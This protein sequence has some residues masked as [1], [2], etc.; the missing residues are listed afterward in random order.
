[1]EKILSQTEEGKKRKDRHEEKTNE[2]IAK[3]IAQ[4]NSEEMVKQPCGSGDRRQKRARD[5]EDEGEDEGRA[6]GFQHDGK[7]TKR[8]REEG[9]QG[10]EERGSARIAVDSQPSNVMGELAAL[11]D[12]CEPIGPS[13]LK[14]YN[15]HRFYD[16][17]TGEEL[18]PVLVAKACEGELQRFEKMQVYR[19]V[20]KTEAKQGKI[21]KVEWVW[22][23]KGMKTAPEVR[24]RLV[25]M[26]FGFNEPRE[27]LFT[28][29]PPLFAM[30]RLLS[31]IASQEKPR[32]KIIMLLDVKCAFLHG[33]TKRT[34]RIELLP[35]D[36]NYRCGKY[37]GLLEKAMYGTRDA[38]QI[39][40]EVVAE[41]M[42]R[43]GFK[44]SLRIHQS[45]SILSERFE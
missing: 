7:G 31:L 36:P 9:D 21:A 19:L 43:L 42:M 35:E 44:A 11:E 34:V 26:E 2:H 32:S 6:K 30:K 8:D 14:H 24:C 3:K 39:W 45:T 17:N 25:A 23:N 22:T 5:Q 15:E 16:E 1:M 41:V 13:L 18:D 4:S 29:T 27:D 37:Y 10:D 12:M 33:G 20:L 38:P 28:G 40:R